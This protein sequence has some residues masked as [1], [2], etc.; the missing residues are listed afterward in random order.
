VHYIV[1]SNTK[2]PLMHLNALINI[3]VLLTRTGSSTVHT[4][5]LVV[6]AFHCTTGNANAARY[7]DTRAFPVF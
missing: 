1:S 6:A 3:F 7:Y 5:G 2:S 4:E